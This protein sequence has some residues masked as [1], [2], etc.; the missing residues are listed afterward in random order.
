MLLI[1]EDL[2]ESQ[3]H[4]EAMSQKKKKNHKVANEKRTE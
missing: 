4:G 2:H 1:P 3:L